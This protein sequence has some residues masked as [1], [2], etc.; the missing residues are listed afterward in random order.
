MG[1]RASSLLTRSTTLKKRPLAPARMQARTMP[2]ARCVL[3]VIG[4]VLFEQN[5][6]WATQHRYMQ[7]E[8]FSKIDAAD[9]D[10]ILGITT[11]AA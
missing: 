2:T 3:P 1:T 6:E 8:A 10:P 9:V 4:A 5:D 11:E 7:V